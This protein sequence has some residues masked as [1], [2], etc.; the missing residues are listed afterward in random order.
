MAHDVHQTLLN[1]VIEKGSRDK[2]EAEIYLQG[3]EENHRYQ[4]DV[5]VV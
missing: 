2:E 5:W 4:K 3:L 1:I